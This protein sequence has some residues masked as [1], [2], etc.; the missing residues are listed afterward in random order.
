MHSRDEQHAQC[1]NARTS[2]LVPDAERAHEAEFH[3]YV[4]FHDFYWFSETN[5]MVPELFYKNVPE[6]P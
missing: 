6:S 5:G 3:Y 1:W 2:W 4:F